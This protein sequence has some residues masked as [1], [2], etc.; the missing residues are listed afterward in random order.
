MDEIFIRKKI[1]AKNNKT[2]KNRKNDSKTKRHETKSTSRNIW[3]Q[4]H[5]FQEKISEID[6]ELIAEIEKSAPRKHSNSD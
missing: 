4:I 3:W 5:L 6:Q 2:Q 1:N